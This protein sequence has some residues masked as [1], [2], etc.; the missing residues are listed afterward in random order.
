M[1]FACG[2][3]ILCVQDP[4]IIP[5]STN[6]SAPET[7]FNFSGFEIG[8]ESSLQYYYLK[9]EFDLNQPNRT[10]FCDY[11]MYTCPANGLW[12]EVYDGCNTK[13][14]GSFGSS[15]NV[16][17]INQVLSGCFHHPAVSDFAYQ[18]WETDVTIT[19][20]QHGPLVRDRSSIKT[21][22]TTKTLQVLFPRFVNVSLNSNNGSAAMVYGSALV[23]SDFYS[24]TYDPMTGI[25]TLQM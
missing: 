14:I 24:E 22:V 20:L 18:V 3:Q 5:P 11:L 2:Q 9:L 15:S 6:V 8:F 21:F 13:L 10:G 19:A 17:L 23:L 25:I 7:F 1:I 16:A 12:S 4:T